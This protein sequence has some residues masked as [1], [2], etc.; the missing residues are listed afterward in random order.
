MPATIQALAR[1]STR[2]TKAWERA[3]IELDASTDAREDEIFACVGN[4]DEHGATRRAPSQP[5]I[6]GAAALLC[7]IRMAFHEVIE[8]FNDKIE[9]VGHGLFGP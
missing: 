7:I 8:M 1:S 6:E 2:R 5:S 4:Q 9:M 3:I